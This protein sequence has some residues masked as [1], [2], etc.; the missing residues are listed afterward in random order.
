MAMCV[1]QLV[2][3]MLKLSTEP[4]LSKVVHTDIADALRRRGVK[5]SREAHLIIAVLQTDAECRARLLQHIDA[6]PHNVIEFVV[7]GIASEY[8]FTKVEA[9]AEATSSTPVTMEDKLSPI[10]PRGNADPPTMATPP[11]TRKR[12]AASGLGGSDTGFDANFHVWSLATTHGIPMRDIM[13]E[14]IIGELT[15]LP[16]A[17][18]ARVVRTLGDALAAGRVP[19]AQAVEALLILTRHELSAKN[20]S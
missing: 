3:R 7:H 9:A 20:V 17:G 5:L 6:V 18:A 13:D 1:S 10:P 8:E 4:D 15:R 12:M 2:H 14:K 19:P 11:R 16:G